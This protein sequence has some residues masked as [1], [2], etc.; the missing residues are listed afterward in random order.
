VAQSKQYFQTYFAR[1]KEKI[2][3]YRRAYYARRKT[4]TL[5]DFRRDRL[6]VQLYGSAL[7]PE[8][9]A[10]ALETEAMARRN[11][12]IAIRRIAYVA[13][14]RKVLCVERLDVGRIY[15]PKQEHP[16]SQGFAR[17]FNYGS[18]AG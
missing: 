6:E 1:N 12:A 9:R 3:A 2:R 15:V 11:D 8:D 5:G 17:Q 18:H 14:M 16:H 7:G 13:S 4:G 10:Y